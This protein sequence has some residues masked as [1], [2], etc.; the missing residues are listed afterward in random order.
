MKVRTGEISLYAEIDENLL[1][2]GLIPILFLHGFTG[3]SKE[4]KF[5]FNRLNKGFLPFA[6]DIVGHGSSDVPDGVSFY[7]AEAMSKQINLFLEKLGF[8]EV[9]ICG[10]SMGGRAALSYYS[11]FPDKVIGLILESATPGIEEEKNR[12]KRIQNDELLARKI[13]TEGVETFIDYW[14]NLPLFDSLK[15]IPEEKYSELIK[16]KKNNNPVGLCASLR[17]F[18]TGSMPVLWDKLDSINFP[19]MLITGHY[20]DK[21]TEINQHIAKKIKTA[22]HVI[23]RDCGHNAHLEKPEEFINLVNKY[24]SD[25]FSGK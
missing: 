10:Y 20:D 7:S 16:W 25:N 8:K 19:T 2:S 9:I 4:W 17:G 18:G 23:I 12:N 14:M 21:F 24:L 6:I 22:K 15:F 11:N 1:N 13:E 3:S 5:I